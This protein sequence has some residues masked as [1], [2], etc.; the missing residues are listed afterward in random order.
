MIGD[1]TG[2]YV[3]LP[4]FKIQNMWDGLRNTHL[5][6]CDSKISAEYV[7]NTIGAEDLEFWFKNRR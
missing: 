4:S 3:I 2:A 5:I 6:E 1:N 7:I